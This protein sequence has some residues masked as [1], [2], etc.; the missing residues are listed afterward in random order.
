LDKQYDLD[1]LDNGI[2]FYNKEDYSNFFVELNKIIDYI[3]DELYHIAGINFKMFTEDD[4]GPFDTFI[5]INSK[6][7]FLINHYIFSDGTYSIRFR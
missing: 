7:R 5:K 2:K 3:E 6:K 1:K 4:F